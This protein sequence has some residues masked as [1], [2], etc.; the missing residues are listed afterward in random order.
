MKLTEV[1]IGAEVRVDASSLDRKTTLRLCE[2]GLRPGC[3]VCVV[4]RT[5]F[6]GTVV[7]CGGHRLALDKLTAG[8]VR[9]C[10]LTA[11][12]SAA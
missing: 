4:Q 3:V 8:S 6:G 10:T 11:A 5:L 7:A 1:P 9:T 12:A 2:L